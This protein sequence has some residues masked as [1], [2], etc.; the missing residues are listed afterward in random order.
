[1]NT[2]AAVKSK[3]DDPQISAVFASLMSGNY[4]MASQTSQQSDKLTGAQPSSGKSSLE[5]YSYRENR[6]EPAQ[7]VTV[8]DKIS[9]AAQELEDVS[10]E[11]IQTVA[12]DLNVDET[13]VEN[14]LAEL[15][16]TAFD[17]LIPQDLAQAVSQISGQEDPAELLMNA[18]F[19]DLMQ[20]MSKVGAELLATLDMEPDQLTELVAQMDIL[21]EPVQ[22]TD[23]EAEL[24]T[25]AAE[26]PRVQTAEQIVQPQQLDRTEAPEDMQLPTEEE[27]AP[28]YTVAGADEAQQSGQN[29][30]EDGGQ[31]PTE[32]G[33]PE[34]ESTVSRTPAQT[35]AEA[36]TDPQQSPVSF[37][38]A[39]NIT[40]EIAAP[41]ENAQSYLSIDTM[42]LIEQIAENVRV[43]ISEGTTS[44][45]MQL[46]PENL[47]K[48]YLQ[49]S[50]KEG[51]IN[52]N[53]AASNEAVRA[54]LEAQVADLRQSLDQAG[55]KVDAIEVTVAS[56]E[57]EQ[58][59]EQNAGREQREGEREQEQASHRRNINLSSMDGLTGVMSE[60]EALVAQIMRDNGNSVDL[61]A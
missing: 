53:I 26:Q 18:Q 15:G 56:H 22:L 38:V 50:A 46:N 58:N 9:D 4:A 48:I 61:T 5:G 16:M 34:Q 44:M 41:E 39:E 11:I 45:E 17:L 23:G 10:D 7:D 31:Q 40:E 6:I 14:A 13:E 19:V 30:N 24:L 36:K 27:S 32:D 20:D 47:G 3:N 54:A 25:T 60:E 37:N 51:V 35:R 52:A 33:A 12:E 49:V 43:N 55:V 21:E 8:S 57:F 29:E 42:D 2:G 59:L 28:E 1:V